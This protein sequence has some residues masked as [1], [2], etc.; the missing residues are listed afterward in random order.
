MFRKTAIVSV[1]ALGL[2]GCLGIPAGQIPFV[3]SLIQWTRYVCGFV[4]TAATLADLLRLD[5]PALTTAE[6]VANAICAE[7]GDAGVMT[8][9][10]SPGGGPMVRGVAINGFFVR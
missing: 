5:W 10:A 6:T 9:E 1:T 8:A 2:S 7:V 3:D 4:P